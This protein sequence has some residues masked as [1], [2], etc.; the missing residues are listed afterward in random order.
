MSGNFTYRNGGLS[1]F[2][3]YVSMVYS[4]FSVAGLGCRVLMIRNCR[5]SLHLSADEAEMK[6]RL[7]NER[8]FFVKPWWQMGRLFF[9]RIG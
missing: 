1:H 7:G 9:C 6:E 8:R 2:F 5:F 3:L 4:V